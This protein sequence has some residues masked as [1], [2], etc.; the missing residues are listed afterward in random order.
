LLDLGFSVREKSYDQGGP[1]DPG[2]SLP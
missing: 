1:A 2:E